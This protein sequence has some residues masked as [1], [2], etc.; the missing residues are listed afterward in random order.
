MGAAINAL[1]DSVKILKKNPIILA[2]GFPAMLLYFILAYVPIIG[3]ALAPLSF[4]GMIHLCRE[5]ASGNASASDYVDGITENAGSIVGAYGIFFLIAMGAGMV[6]MVLFYVLFFLIMGGGMALAGATES[7]AAAGGALGLGFIVMILL[8]VLL[9]VVSFVVGM[10]VQF[11]DVSIVLGGESATS[12]FSRSWEVVKSDP[13]STIGFTLLRGFVVSVITSAP[14]V[15]LFGF[16]IG[17]SA[18]GV[19]GDIAG[20]ILIGALLV[21]IVAAPIGFAFQ[22]AYHTAYFGRREATSSSKS[23]ATATA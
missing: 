19:S 13:V 22:M 5:G 14:M 2:M 18:L 3:I 20:I 11:L 16:A 21:S 4:A 12:A 17:L 1:S 9:F 8:Y 15:V 7:G 10:V 23:R 6:L